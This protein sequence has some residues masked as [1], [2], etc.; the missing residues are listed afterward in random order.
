MFNTKRK[1]KKKKAIHNF[2]PFN[3][4]TIESNN[5]RLDQ[6]FTIMKIKKKKST[7]K[8]QKR[9][10]HKNTKHRTQD[11]FFSHFRTLFSFLGNQNGIEFW[12][13][14]R[15]KKR[16]IRRTYTDTNKREKRRREKLT[17]A[18]VGWTLDSAAT[19]ALAA[20]KT[21]S[22]VALLLLLLRLPMVGFGCAKGSIFGSP[23]IGNRRWRN[24]FAAARCNHGFGKRRIKNE[25]KKLRMKRKVCV[26]R[27]IEY[28]TEQRSEVKWRWN[29]QWREYY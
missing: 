26:L 12:K 7:K 13:S 10:K 21:V 9:E 18:S 8:K 5:R 19:M 16:G 28:S 6:T 23:E 29:W 27:M 14:K 4:T 11:P 15:K 1:E 25:R 20:A 17:G 2:K 22:A 24:G 3:A